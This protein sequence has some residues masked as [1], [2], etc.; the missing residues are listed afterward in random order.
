MAK[1]SLLPAAALLTGAEIIA[2]VQGGVTRRTTTAAIAALAG[3]DSAAQLRAELISEDGGARV[4][5]LNYVP[6]SVPLTLEQVLSYAPY[7]IMNCIPIEYHAAILN[8]DWANVPNLSVYVQAAINVMSARGGVLEC[9]PGAFRLSIT[10]PENITIRGAALGGQ[11]GILWTLP[12]ANTRTIFRA[13]GTSWIVHQTADKHVGALLGID[14]LGNGATANEGGVLLEGYRYALRDC[15]F[16]NFANQGAIHWGLC[17]MVDN[18]FAVACVLNRVRNNFIGALEYRG[19]DCHISNIETTASITRAEGANGIINKTLVR[20]FTATTAAGSKQLTLPSNVTGIQLGDRITGAGVPVGAQVMLVDVA[21]NIVHLDQTCTASAAAVPIAASRHDLWICAY[22]YAGYNAQSTQ[23]LAEIAERGVHSIHFSNRF[24][25][26]RFDRNYGPGIS[27][28]FT[29]DAS[30]TSYDNSQ[31]G[32]GLY[33]GFEATLPGCYG[34]GARATS[35][36]VPLYGQV[37][38]HRYGVNLVLAAESSAVEMRPNFENFVSI[39]HKVSVFLDSIYV[40]SAVSGQRQ[41]FIGD[42]GATIDWAH[43]TMVIPTNSTPVNVTKH[44]GLVPNMRYTIKGNPN[45]T[46]KANAF[47]EPKGTGDIACQNRKS[48][49]FTAMPEFLGEPYLGE[50]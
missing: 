25:A 17:G 50:N 37:N 33:D 4:S 18:I 12:T 41:V 8:F 23:I 42:V 49:S 10:L 19:N 24:S 47:M 6:G 14:F 29:T 9:P 46:L 20:N 36:D 31:G 39:G 21:S 22:L 16:Y 1:Y 38:H 7:S 13:I 28:G 48:Y 44:V 30:C 3:P 45:V 5:I 11:A 2:L 15:S 35:T 43:I 32:D 26:S 27:G 34:G 40:T